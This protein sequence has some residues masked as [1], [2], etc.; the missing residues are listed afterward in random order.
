LGIKFNEIVLKRI[1][2]YCHRP[3]RL[4][5]RPAM[6]GPGLSATSPAG[7]GWLSFAASARSCHLGRGS[8][9]SGPI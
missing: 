7:A 8:G 5:S 4:E 6:T 1:K 9:R 2:T 3:H